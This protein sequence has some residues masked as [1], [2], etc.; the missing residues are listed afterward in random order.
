MNEITLNDAMPLA[1]LTIGEARQFFDGLI[2]SR[3]T[4][5]V[6]LNTTPPT[7]EVLDLDGAV[8]YLYDLGYFITKN[9]LYNFTTTGRIPCRRMGRRLVF[10]RTELTLW[11][12]SK[13]KQSPRQSDAALLVAKSATRK[14]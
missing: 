4:Q 7:S 5:V 6:K 11:V 12:E 3:L 8:A 13:V 2:S 9:A 10:N 14:R 1:G